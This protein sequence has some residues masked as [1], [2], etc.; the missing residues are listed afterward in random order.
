MQAGEDTESY[1]AFS[2]TFIKKLA[3]LGFDQGNTIFVP[4]NHDVDREYTKTKLLT[5]LALRE[6][7]LSEKQ[8]NDGMRTDF[9]EHLF[10]KFTK[11]LEWQRQNSNLNLYESFAG[12]GFALTDHL[13]IYCLNTALFSFGGLEH[14]ETSE[15]I[16]DE[17]HLPVETRAIHEWMQETSFEFRILAMHHPT[18]C[19][20][21]WARKEIDA[22]I[23]SS[24][25]LVLC[26]HEHENSAYHQEG[27]G[28]SYVKCI[29]PP[30]FTSKL[31]VSGYSLLD[32][33]V[34]PPG[35]LLRYRHWVR[36]NYVT[37]TALSATDDGTVRFGS[38]KIE[39]T[40]GHAGVHDINGKI[41][42]HLQQD[43]D[44]TLKCYS[45]LPPLWA[46]RTISDQPERASTGSIAVL[47]TAD[48]L[49]SNLRDCVI[50][51]P[52]QFGLS[53]LSRY[54]ALRHWQTY[55]G[56]FVAVLEASECENHES[57][58]K[59]KITGTL[60]SYGVSGSNLHAVI[61]DGISVERDRLINNV[62][63]IY[64]DLPVMVLLTIEHPEDFD[65]PLEGVIKF[66]HEDL[67]L[68]QLD[69][70]QIRELVTKFIEAGYQLA[71]NQAISHLVRDLETL[72]LHRSPL[73]CMTLLRV[74]ERQIDYSPANR[75]EML[76][77]FLYL[78]FA[79]YKKKPDYS[80]FPDL[81]DSLYV[82]GYFCESLIR[83]GDYSF[84]K[85]RFLRQ[86]MQYCKSRVIDID[87][88]RLF[89][90]LAEENIILPR[91]RGYVFRYTSW[92]SFFCAHRM[93]H[94]REFCEFVLGERRYIN[95][96]EMIE[97][98]SGIDRRR[99]KLVAQLTQDLKVLTSSFEQRSK[100]DKAYDPYAGPKW[101]VS[102]TDAGL[103]EQSIEKEVRSA[104]LPDAVK[105]SILDRTYDGTK[106][107]RQVISSFVNDS[108]LH[109]CCLVLRCA[110]RVLRNSDF[111]NPEGKL[112][113]LHEI[114]VAWS[115]SFQVISLLS[116]ILAYQRHTEYENIRYQ[117][118]Y[119][120]D[121]SME[122]LFVK[123]MEVLPQN[124]VTYYEADLASAR[125]RPLLEEFMKGSS[126]RRCGAEDIEQCIVA[127]ILLRQ[128]PP[129]WYDVVRDYA[130]SLSKDSLYL[131]SLLREAL[132][133]YRYGF[134]T[135]P[136]RQ[137]LED[138]MGIVLAKHQLGRKRPAKTLIRDIGR[139]F[140]Q[141]NVEE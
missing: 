97:F 91:G 64:A 133:E 29:A 107:Y 89:S 34:A 120:G 134:C 101:A 110:A 75:T 44:R 36:P 20:S 88:A 5:L 67:Y 39:D 69:R 9:G 128:R 54:I 141:K 1:N 42:Q 81:K 48:E 30:L 78:I 11:Y 93:H 12:A 6:Q 40:S 108:S 99:D 138:I 76:E 98:Y 130:L 22:L 25:D 65:T 84:T 4:G 18:K 102:Q 90:V 45:S 124:V 35:I 23:E 7:G 14:P 73:T 72:N 140:V 114:L 105:D 16:D 32:L 71:E 31:H 137:Q 87:C 53:T 117:L 47:G 127:T 82:L 139:K 136:Q 52:P 126:G 68:W 59:E 86:S 15:R 19:L 85:E 57:A 106:P 24:F 100:I 60:H 46:P 38:Y 62:K 112:E 122:E 116:P 21:R 125:I 115:K 74:Y 27:A 113:L 49:A 26:G 2:E 79:D 111:V 56:Q 121:A 13:G 28:G 135:Q 33:N 80:N 55:P 37:G 95:F 58:I 131:K 77:R 66:P 83:G 92:I 3:P 94:D 103:L 10:P 109:E 51:A 70:Q 63:K 123:I 104:N 61:L 8:F 118:L 50:M 132:H 43:L 129:G 17:G 96:P 41:A 119:D